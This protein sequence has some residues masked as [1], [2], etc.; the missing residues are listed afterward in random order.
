MPRFVLIGLC[1]P[2]AADR[3]ADFDE[4][5]VG[6]HIEDTTRCPH[7]VRGS[8]YRLAG[9]HLDI[10]SV[11]AYLSVYE[12]EAPS[13]EEAE[14]V[15]NQWQAD[16]DAWPGRRAHWATAKRIGQLPMAV[17]GSGWYEQIATYDGPAAA[18]D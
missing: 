16:P 18:A 6:E 13:Y 15:L 4:W 2:T 3:Q 7:V 14:R 5:F 10:E 1:E 8:V 12:V 9:P 11:S 17:R